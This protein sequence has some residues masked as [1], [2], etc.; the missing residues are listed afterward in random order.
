MKVR[1]RILFLSLLVAVLFL[2][3][4]YVLRVWQMNRIT[5]LQRQRAQ[6]MHQLID[7]LIE[8]RG[9]SLFTY[10]YD[11]TIWDEMAAFVKTKNPEWAKEN[12]IQSL[13]TFD[14]QALWVFDE[15][16]TVVYHAALKNKVETDIPFP[17]AADVLP[18]LFAK[19][20]FVHFFAESTAGFMEIRGATVH[21]TA[22]DLRKTAPQGYFFVGRLWNGEFLG[23]LSQLLNGN[24]R[25]VPGDIESPDIA[26]GD[27]T[28]SIL[29]RHPLPGWN[30][31]PAAILEVEMPGRIAGQSAWYALWQLRLAFFFALSCIVLFFIT[32]TRW[33][34][35]PTHTL[36][37]ALR[38]QNLAALDKLKSD[39]SEFGN[40]A[41]LIATYFEQQ[42]A[43]EREVLARARAEAD[44]SELEGSFKV[45]LDATNDWVFLT[46]AE[47][48]FLAANRAVCAGFKTSIEELRNLTIFHF[49]PPDKVEIRRAQIEHVVRTASSLRAE[50]DY[51]ERCFEVGIYPVIN[52]EGKVAKLA[53][54]AHDVTEHRN[55]EEQRKHLEAQL[56]QSQKIESVGR[57]AGGVAH[58]FNNLLSPILGYAELALEQIPESEPL[59]GD[60]EQIR[61][62]A[63]RA[64]DLT[65][66]LLAFSRKQVLDVRTIVINDF[67]RE[68]DGMLRRLIGEDIRVVT[69]LEPD[70][71]KVKADPSQ[72][73]QIVINL[74]VNARDAM[75]QGGILTIETNNVVLDEH[76][77]SV[78]ASMSP[79]HYVLLAISDNGCGMTAEVK[80]RIFEPF[81]TT[82]ERGKGTG[83]G[84]A[85]VYGIVKQH[86]GNIWVYSEEGCG[87][88]FKVYFPVADTEKVIDEHINL[89][90]SNSFGNETILVTE[91]DAMVRR[92][93]CDVLEAHGYRVIAA[94]SGD[95]ALELARKTEG[96]IDLLLTD[97]IMPAMNGKDL[98]GRLSQE[99]QN[100]KV[101]YMS[102]YTGEIIAHH[103][104][105]ES[106]THF[107]PK[108]FTLQELTQ[109]IR[110]ALDN[111]NIP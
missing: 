56:R 65:R 48:R 5:A 60:I 73:Q 62:A 16:F 52:P 24:T 92:L 71:E 1:T 81:F 74:A 51:D 107:I 109:K 94:D 32:F 17:I 43:F 22:D 12:L 29:T 6:E 89:S 41:R 77:A 78:H 57:L 35:A 28:E 33:V 3:S 10:S 82:K 95:Q 99:Y 85:T 26:Y 86:G 93:T 27:S 61:I 49:V 63:R 108:P 37:T 54:F 91:D 53:F 98:Y 104:I 23:E 15:G 40:L 83:L 39:P 21:S 34:V 4:V 111:S 20:R 2:A 70:L 31:L 79:G 105:L 87:T 7:K 30:G 42:K 97:V 106:G 59:H 103:G 13:P 11:Y 58:D 8:L 80:Q 50:S 18:N 68:V 110:E 67:I 101:V 84:L 72:L 46:D 76:Y 69:K 44:L 25:I 75:P 96:K 47:G 36:S 45:L 100:L 9:K 14:T 90:R 64:R 55:L 38:T 88:S 66:Q 102:G 19:E